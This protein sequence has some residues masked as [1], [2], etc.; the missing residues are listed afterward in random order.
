MGV[1]EKI[2]N[3]KLIDGNILFPDLNKR[4]RNVII[5]HTRL[6]VRI[7]LFFIH[8]KEA[9]INGIKSKKS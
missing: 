5:F 7:I 2:K 8:I 3:A 1:K 4:Q 9:I 6:R